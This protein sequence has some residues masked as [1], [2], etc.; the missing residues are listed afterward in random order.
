[1]SD[2]DL[3][4]YDVL[5]VAPS[6]TKEEIRAA[7]QRRLDEAQEQQ[8]REHA[9]KRPNESALASARDDEVGLRSAWQVLSDPYQ[10]GRYDASIDVPDGG[11]AADVELVGDTPATSGATRRQA[12]AEAAAEARANRPPGVFSTDRPPTPESWPEGVHPPPPRA[13]LLAMLV[14]MVL[15][16]VILVI[17]SAFVGPAVL[18]EMYPKETKQLDALDVQADKLEKQ[19]TVAEDCA[20]LANDAARA[21]DDRCADGL[22]TKQDANAEIDRLENQIEKNDDRQGD[23]NGEM[24]TGQFAVAFGILFAML[25]Y[26]LPSTMRT[27]RTLG[28]ACFRIRLIQI[29]GRPVTF[30]PA[31]AHYGTPLLFAQFT[32]FILGPL[33][34]MVALFG[35]LMWPRNPNLQGLHDR[36]AKTIVVD[37]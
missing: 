3:T 37:G 25:L 17:G 28:K 2:D 4:H 34:Y 33:S 24:A 27:G 18:D 32:A 11:G 31:L 35:V 19:K 15:L 1:V 30:R 22:A 20:D 21:D 23:L 6:A 26:L 5:G 29:D 9:S 36:L 10:R 12:R 8:A 16:A 13:R 14:D 7:Y